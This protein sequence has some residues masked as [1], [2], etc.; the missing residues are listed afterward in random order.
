MLKWLLAIVIALLLFSGLTPWLRRMGLGKLPGD[1]TFV[2][3]GRRYEFPLGS[4]ILLSLL[5]TL[6]FHMLK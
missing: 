2:R 5:A 1:F 4:T 6:L 3:D